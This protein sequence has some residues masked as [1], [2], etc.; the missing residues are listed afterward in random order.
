M[1]SAT[2]AAFR[3]NPDKVSELINLPQNVYPV[4]GLCLGYPD[5]NPELKPRL[6]LELVLMEETYQPVNETLLEEYDNTMRDYYQQRTNG[7][8]DRMWSQDMSALLGKESRPHMKA[9][10]ESKGF[11]LR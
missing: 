3:N 1:A 9:F 2:L 8:V 10:L 6:P 11:K 5:Q 7:K 4:F